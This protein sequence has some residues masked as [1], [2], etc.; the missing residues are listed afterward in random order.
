MLGRFRFIQSAVSGQSAVKLLLG[1]QRV[2][3]SSIA[4]QLKDVTDA[5]PMKEAVRYQD[6]NFKCTREDIDAYSYALSNGLLELCVAPNDTMVLWL[7]DDSAEKHVAMLAA[8]K[9][10]VTVAD[11]S[12]DVQKPEAIRQVL[13]DTGA[14]MIMI[15]T[16]HP[17]Y[18]YLHA[19]V[20][21]VPELLHF[22]DKHGVPFHS[23]TLPKLRMFFHTGYD[24]IKGFCNFK[25]VLM[26]NPGESQVPKILPFLK[27][28]TPLYTP[29]TKGP[30]GM[31]V[32]GETLT[33]GQ[34]LSHS[35]W[36][37]HSAILGGQYVEVESHR[38][39]PSL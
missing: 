32:K 3:F 24:V 1:S 23:H 36:K 20:K 26:F 28:D 37:V 34:V 18:N 17:D 4:A 5:N 14:R 10:G 21:A 15:D 8:A 16:E 12:Q 30:D 35:A 25:H 6:K 29:Y 33:N 2:G 7:P 13:S 19:L 9:M 27:D 39:L 31:A 38:E 22:N 11:V